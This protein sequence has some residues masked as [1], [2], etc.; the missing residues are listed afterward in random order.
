MTSQRMRKSVSEARFGIDELVDLGEPIE[1]LACTQNLRSMFHRVPSLGQIG[2]HRLESINKLSKNKTKYF[3]YLMILILLIVIGSLFARVAFKRVR[4]SKH[5]KIA[6]DI[7]AMEEPAAS[8]VSMNQ[9]GKLAIVEAL[10]AKDLT[11]FDVQLMSLRKYFKL[12]DLSVFLIVVAPEDIAEVRRFVQSANSRHNNMFPFRIVEATSIVPELFFLTKHS[13]S[14]TA[15]YYKEH[16]FGYITRMIAKL[17]AAEWVNSDFYLAL[18]ADVLCVRPTSYKSLITQEGKASANFGP[19]APQSAYQWKGAAQLLDAPQSVLTNDV[20]H[21]GVA[22]LYHRMGVHK[23]KT[24]LE[25]VY[26]QP[27]RY[28]LLRYLFGWS[29]YSLY[30]SF[31]KMAGLFEKYHVAKAE[32][33]FRTKGVLAEGRI[34]TAGWKS[35][36]FKTALASEPEGSFVHLHGLLDADKDD[37]SY[38]IKPLFESL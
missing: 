3:G 24:Y 30:Y 19:M 15:P 20:V 32:G 34:G 25:V 16:K 27:W 13:E 31:L 5:M 29:D 28:S 23:L 37:V 14:E 26:Q 35:W 17:A 21:G 4:E 9:E 12:S 6:E 8:I 11:A 22:S 7:G 33:V 2:L 1:K 18:D 10:Q 38:R 36:D